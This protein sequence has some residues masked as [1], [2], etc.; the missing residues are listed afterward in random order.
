MSRTTVG[1]IANPASGKDIRRLVAHGTVF[2]NQEKT[3]IVRRLLLACLHSGV[4]R[5]LYMPDYHGLV[6]KAVAGLSSDYQR[7]TRKE[8]IKAGGCIPGSQCPS[9]ALCFRR[10]CGG[11]QGAAEKWADTGTIFFRPDP[12]SP[13]VVEPVDMALTA[14]QSDSMNAASLMEKTGCGCLMVLGGDGTSRQVAKG[15]SSVPLLSVSTGTNNVFPNMTEATT[16]GLAAAA[17]ARGLA[18]DE[19]IYRAK[20]LVIIKNGQ[21]VD[22]ALVDAVV[23]SGHFI[24]SRAIWEVDSMVEAAFTSGETDNIGLASIVGKSRPVGVRD[25]FGAWVVFKPG[26]RDVFAPIAPGLFKPVGLKEVSRLEIGQE[27]KV[28]QIHGL[29][30]LDGEREVELGEGDQAAICLDDQGP[31][32]VDVKAALNGAVAA[33]FFTD[34][35]FLNRFNP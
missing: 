12:K 24:G 6:E 29:I 3:N 25:P 2:D 35:A 18:G 30:A 8:L 20:R 10:E 14:T 33:G 26:G 31:L 34:A 5:V 15:T 27:R 22:L 4:D 23:S 16:A 17:V 21:P 13:L 7:A 1:I 28:T 19:A 9:R 32:V 11:C